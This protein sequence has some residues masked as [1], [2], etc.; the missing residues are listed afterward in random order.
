MKK[1][2]AILSIVTMLASSCAIHKGMMHNSVSLSINNFSYVKRN[3]TGSA[4]TM[5]I[6]GVGGFTKKSLID[7]AKRNLLQDNPLNNNQALANVAVSEKFGMYFVVF[8]TEV[9]ITADIVEFR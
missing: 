4:K 1:L 3:V 8:V 9:T 2:I 6:F 7:E 5:N